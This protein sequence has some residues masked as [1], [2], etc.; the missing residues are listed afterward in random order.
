ML[1]NI[2]TT[3]LRYD[4]VLACSPF[5]C[6]GEE[7]KITSHI[8]ECIGLRYQ[9][10]IIINNCANKKMQ[11]YRWLWSV[12]GATMYITFSLMSAKLKHHDQ[13]EIVSFTEGFRM[14]RSPVKISFFLGVVTLLAA[15][16]H[17]FNCFRLHCLFWW[18]LLWSIINYSTKN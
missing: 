16:I 14:M 13:F 3:F 17:F 8:S 10:F 1:F 9:F 18:I 4:S 6:Y 5:I 11:E 12:I 15:R 7:L 2:I